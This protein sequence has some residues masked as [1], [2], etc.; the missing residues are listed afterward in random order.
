MSIVEE[1]EQKIQTLSPQELMR[2]SDWFGDFQWQHWDTKL[3]A[4]SSA[5]KLDALIADA[6]AQHAAGRSR[7]V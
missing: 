5:G 2:F 4:D 1:L 7:V 6:R 3:E